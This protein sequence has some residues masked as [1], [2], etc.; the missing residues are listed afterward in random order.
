MSISKE[1]FA[2]CGKCK[3][4]FSLGCVIPCPLDVFIAAGKAA[5]CPECGETKEIFI[6]KEGD[7]DGA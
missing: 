7:P 5:R 3:K 2:Q 1:C 4:S 6:H